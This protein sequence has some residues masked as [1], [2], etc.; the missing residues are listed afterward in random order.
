MVDDHRPR[1]AL[2]LGTLAGIVDDEGI[3]VGQGAQRRLGEAIG[4]QRQRLA[5]QPFQI[6]V[7]AHMDHRIGTKSVLKPGVEGQIIVRR[8]QIGVVI[9]GG[10]IDIVAARRLHRDRYLTETGCRQ[11]EIA[12]MQAARHKERIGLRRAPPPGHG[13]AQALGKAVEIRVVVGQRQGLADLAAGQGAPVIGGSGLHP[14][15]QGVAIGRNMI[16]IIAGGPQRPQ[17]LDGGGG[18]IEADAVAQTAVAVGI[19][20]QNQG[21]PPLGR[22]L[23]P[24]AGPVGRQSGDEGDAVGDRD[25]TGDIA[26]GGGVASRRLE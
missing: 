23:A 21:H 15:D 25:M 19:V 10:G 26:L 5:R 2:G 20:G 7:L 13:I 24:Q 12:A 3:K 8:R 14:F 17:H 22:D 18:G 1:P 16:E 11:D 6:A 4:R 9:A